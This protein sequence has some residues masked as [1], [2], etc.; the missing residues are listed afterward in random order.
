VENSFPV[1]C[2]LWTVNSVA[3][4]TVDRKIMIRRAVSAD[5]AALAELAARTFIDAFAAANR[6]EDIEAFVGAT[7]GEVQQRRE[8]E[9]PDGITLLFEEDGVLHGF[10]QL[11]RTPDSRDGEVEIARFYV[12]QTRHGR[13]VA[14]AL[15]QETI[16]TARELGAS[17]VWLGVWEHN[18]RAIRFYEK[19]GFRDVGSHPF[20]L[21]TDLQTDRIMT[22]VI[23]PR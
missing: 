19:S 8:I 5:A 14:P 23:P 2:A 13:G 3:L 17:T 20:L 16:A 7:Y 15:M 12:D 22:F 11:R 18:P 21:G 6:A 4:C 9:N 10:V 1:Y